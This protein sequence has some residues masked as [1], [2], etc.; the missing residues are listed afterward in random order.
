MYKQINK[1][2]LLLIVFSTIS[3]KTEVKTEE[4]KAYESLKNYLKERDLELCP[5][6]AELGKMELNTRNAADQKYPDFGT[7]NLEYL[8]TIRIEEKSKLSKKYNIADSMF[9][10][11]NVYGNIHC[12]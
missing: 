4:E 11:I 8:E 9:V 7:E 2:A 6:Y 10:K 12:K 3:C 1:I 5:F